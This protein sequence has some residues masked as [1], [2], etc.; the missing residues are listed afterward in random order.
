M[1]YLLVLSGITKWFCNQKGL[2][3]NVLLIDKV[4]LDFPSRKTEGTVSLKL[5]VFPLK[6]W[7]NGVCYIWDLYAFK[8]K[9]PLLGKIV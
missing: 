8:I 4:S 1:H 6:I 5:F 7:K 9:R 2:R 3:G